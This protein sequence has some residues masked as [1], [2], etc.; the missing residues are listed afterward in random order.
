M[1]TNPMV[2]LPLSGSWMRNL[3]LSW[4]ES[5]I[6]TLFNL[7]YSVMFYI[8]PRGVLSLPSMSGVR[9]HVYRS[10]GN[11]CLKMLDELLEHVKRLGGK[12]LRAIDLALNVNS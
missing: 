12:M 1:S 10:T 11:C 8:H 7:R 3:G 6:K 2:P 5:G 4:I 9:W